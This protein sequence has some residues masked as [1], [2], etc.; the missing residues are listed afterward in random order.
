MD[1]IHKR[2]YHPET[3]AQ[4]SL[5][6][7]INVPVIYLSS[8]V[9]CAECLKIMENIKMVSDLESEYHSGRFVR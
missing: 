4:T 9:T 5:C 6:G 2:K 7:K 1:I 8:H 3:G